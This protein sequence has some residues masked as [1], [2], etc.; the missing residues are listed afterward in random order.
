[1]APIAREGGQVG[2]DHD[3]GD[4]LG[5]ELDRL[6]GGVDPQPL[7]HPDQRLARKYRIVKLVAGVVQ[8]NDE[9]VADELVGPDPL[10]VGDVLNTDLARGGDGTQRQAGEEEQCEARCEHGRLR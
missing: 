2:R 4:V 1:M 10:D 5:L 3:R 7:Q 9:A 6:V 8:A